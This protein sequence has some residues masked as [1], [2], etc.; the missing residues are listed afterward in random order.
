L[1][2]PEKA[3]V[4]KL[5]QRQ[6]HKRWTYACSGRVF[7]GV[8]LENLFKKNY[9]EEGFY[10]GEEVDLTDEE[11]SEP[12]RTEEGEAEELRQRELETS[13]TVQTTEVS[14]NDPPVVSETLNHQNSQNHQSPQSTITSSSV[15]TQT[16]NLGSSM[17]DEM[18]L[19]IFRG[20]G[21]EDPDQHWFL[22]EAV[23]NIKNITD[24]VV[25]RNQFSTTLR[26]RALSWYM[27]LVQGLA[28]PKPLNEIKN[29]L[30]AEFKK[31]KSE[32]QC[33]T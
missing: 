7:R 16:G 2:G 25:K 33:I 19:P 3:N 21:S 32:S 11:H 8:H 24:E 6:R 31:P 26:D 12:T 20:D 14:N 29:A 18:R 23:W 13:G 28:Q 5:G 27:K 10:S 9:G 1:A 22:C 17:V 4:Q 15:S 30:V